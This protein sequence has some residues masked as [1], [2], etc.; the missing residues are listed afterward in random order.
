MAWTFCGPPPT[1]KHHAAHH[2]GIK[3]NNNW[4]NIRWKTKAEN[5]LDKIRH[6]TIPKADWHFR[7]VL[8]RADVAEI[9]RLG[10]NRKRGDIVRISER[11]G[12]TASHISAIISGD[13]RKHG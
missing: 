4:E 9:R 8:S 3:S 11:F 5:E 1:P 13:H 7:S 12:V 10:E 6:G 2:D